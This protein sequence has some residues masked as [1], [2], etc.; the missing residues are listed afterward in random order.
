M[1]S[2]HNK[3]YL[4]KSAATNFIVETGQRQTLPIY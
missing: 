3:K 2:R 4:E 1:I